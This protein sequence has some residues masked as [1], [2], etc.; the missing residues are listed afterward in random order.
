MMKVLV[1]GSNGQV[2]YLLANKLAAMSDIELLA[3]DKNELDI[4]DAS[5]VNQVVSGFRPDVVINAAAYT[6]VDKAEV[7]QQLA[8]DINCKGPRNLAEAAD[9]CGALLIHISTDYVFPG[10][11]VGEY[12]EN[13]ATG[14]SS[15]YG[16]TK[17]DGE[18]AVA[19]VCHRHI[20]LRTA[21]VF[22]EHGNN[23]VKTMLRLAQ[24]HPQLRI[25][26]DQ[27]GGPTYAGDLADTIIRIMDSLITGQSSAY[28]IYHYSGLPHVN[29]SEFAETIF[30]KAVE[31][32]VIETLPV[33]T[34]ITTAEYPTPACRPANSKLNT[35]RITQYFGV[36]A[37]DW[38]KAL[39][40]IK[41]Y[42]S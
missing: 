10:D 33:V 39:N 17:L 9:A 14:P 40:S 15:V 11:K 2:G 12:N 34:R 21:W 20:I 38:K 36:A 29:W 5:A 7:E 16:K 23:F 8:N 6:A 30:E 19:L 35:Q 37:S 1:T 42:K 28:G 18:L 26:A 25:V 32:K 41:A 13:D 22:G 27:V 24:T 31:E 3:V 4:V